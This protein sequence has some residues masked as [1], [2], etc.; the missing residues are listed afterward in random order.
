MPVYKIWNCDRNVRKSVVAISIEEMIV[1]VKAKFNLGNEFDSH[2]IVTEDDGTE[3]E[4][5]EVLQELGGGTTFMLLNNGESWKPATSTSP[6]NKIPE[7]AVDDATPPT[8]Q[9]Q[10]SPEAQVSSSHRVTEFSSLPVF[11]PR[12]LEH[13]RSGKEHMVWRE[14]ISEAANYYIGKHPQ[15]SSTSE[16]CAIGRKMFCTYPS[17]QREGEHEWSFFTKCLSQRIRHIRWTDRKRTPTE[18]RGGGT[19]NC[20]PTTKKPRVVHISCTSDGSSDLTSEEYEKHLSEIQV[21][22][23]KGQRKNDAHLNLL[24]SECFK[25]NQQWIKG[26]PDSKIKPILEKIPCY[27]DGQMIILEFQRII[28]E[29]QFGKLQDNTKM[30]MAAVEEALRLPPTEEPERMVKI[31]EQVEKAT[32]FDKGKGVKTKRVITIIEDIPDNEVEVALKTG[33]KDP[34]K[35]V[36]IKRDDKIT[37]I[38]IVGDGVHISCKGSMVANAVI[39]LL[40]VYYVFN[41]DYPK[42][43]SQ[44]LGILQTHVV[45]GLPFEGK[46]SAKYRTFNNSLVKKMAQ[47]RCKLQEPERMVKIIEQVEK[48]TAFDKGKGVKTKRVITITEDIPDNEVEVALKTGDK[49]PPK[50]VIIKR[51]DKITAIFIVG[52]GVRISCKGSMV[53]NAVITL[54]GVYYVFNLD[55]PKIYSQILGILQTHVV[56]GLP[57]E[58]KKSA[59]YRTFNNSLVK[60]MAQ[61]RCSSEN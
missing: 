33:D 4:D 35:L 53:A 42:I 1:K 21:E 6:Q 16:Y 45:G 28:G 40:G 30:F 44:I 34:P 24:L 20:A 52:D 12:V 50:L 14:L 2:R 43:Y 3:I 11:S 49:D 17:I 18:N 61:K 39:T 8:P 47:K 31:I 36:I 48:A 22:W 26:L 29:K 38:F 57:F 23:A 9:S 55:Y 7:P 25:S 60:K 32:A 15:L 13:L 27:E 56:G 54:L 59:K 51:D 19:D 5:D 46:K 37:A 58:G 41:L 10:C